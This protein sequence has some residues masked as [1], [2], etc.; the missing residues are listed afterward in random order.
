MTQIVQI[1]VMNA[2]VDTRQKSKIGAIEIEWLT[3][4]KKNHIHTLNNRWTYSSVQY[5]L[6]P[7][8]KHLLKLDSLSLSLSLSA[9]LQGLNILFD[10]IKY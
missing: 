2:Y 5:S 7:L 8:Q 1:N 4:R 9:A 3:I 10:M 6:L